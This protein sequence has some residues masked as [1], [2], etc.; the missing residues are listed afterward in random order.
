MPTQ[1]EANDISR[2]C[3]VWS[4]LERGS[5]VIDDCPWQAKTQDKVRK[6]DVFQK[7]NPNAPEHF[8]SSKPALL[9][10]LVAGL[11]YPVR[12]LTG[13]P[14]QA[15]VLQPRTPRPDRPDQTQEPVRWPAYVFYFKSTIVALNVVPYLFFLIYFAK[16]LDRIVRNDWAWFAGLVSAA[17]ATPL[18]IFNTTLNNHS[19]AAFSAF[20]AVY[21]LMRIWETPRTPASLS[22]MR[23]PA[24]A[25]ALS[26]VRRGRLLRR[27]RGL[28]RASR[29]DV[30]NPPVP[31][32]PS[33][34]RPGR[35]SSP[36]SRPRRSP[37]SPSSPR[38][39]SRPAASRPSTPSSGGLPMNM[40][41]ATGSIPLRWTGSTRTP[42]RGGSI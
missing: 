23:I 26:H 28:Q 39:T 7:G 30:R 16:R 33:S 34:A 37:A 6:P 8:Y 25:N 22:R 42:S 32:R 10:T 27:V 1:L 21:A 12:K 15:E 20:F 18:V 3:T 4:L 38:S 2:W 17:W 36:S 13:V 40:R 35:R 11:L 29:G 9:P 14:L 19:V 24:A 41:G 31:V 5:Y